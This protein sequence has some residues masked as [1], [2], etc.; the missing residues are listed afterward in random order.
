MDKRTERY[1]SRMPL[2]LK[3]RIKKLAKKDGRS[4]SDMI[5]VLLHLGT[6]V[7]EFNLEALADAFTEQDED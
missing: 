4:L 1:Y 2:D 6:Y 5:T 7:R 3:C